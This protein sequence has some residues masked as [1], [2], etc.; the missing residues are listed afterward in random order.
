[1]VE[2]IWLSQQEND[3]ST[4]TVQMS[5]NTAKQPQFNV[6][7]TN[8]VPALHISSAGLMDW[9]DGGRQ[10]EREGRRSC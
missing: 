9:M 10:A 3:D 2:L 8:F 4:I 1:M 5:R 6:T 7:L